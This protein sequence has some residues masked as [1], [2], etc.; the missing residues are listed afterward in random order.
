MRYRKDRLIEADAA[1]CMTHA[2]RAHA[3]AVGSALVVTDKVGRIY[4]GY[5]PDPGLEPDEAEM[6]NAFQALGRMIGT[7]HAANIAAARQKTDT[8]TSVECP[9]FV[10]PAFPYKRADGR[11]VEAYGTYLKSFSLAVTRPHQQDR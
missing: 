5:V 1:T 10:M 11:S 9:V 6:R 4:F 7:D 8:R 3:L 2:C